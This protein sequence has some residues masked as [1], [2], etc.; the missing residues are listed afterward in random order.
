M[1]QISVFVLI[2][3]AAFLHATWNLLLKSIPDSLVAIA[4]MNLFAEIVMEIIVMIV[5]IVV[6]LTFILMDTIMI[7]M[8][9]VILVIQMMIMM[10]Y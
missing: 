8:D 4:M 2:L 10:E 1:T 6:P 7:M 5:H 9:Y 3:F